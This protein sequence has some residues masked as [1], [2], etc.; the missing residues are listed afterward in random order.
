M[1]TLTM[2]C[3]RCSKEV[4]HDMTDQTLNNDLVR[5][6]GF[7]YTHNGKRNVLLCTQ[8]EKLLRELKVKLDGIIKTETCSFFEDCGKDGE[9]GDKG[10]PKDE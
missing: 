6:F 1:I 7:S 9:D 2:K 5:K 10:K 4:S 3:A 8:C